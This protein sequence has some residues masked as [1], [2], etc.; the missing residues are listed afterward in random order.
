[1]ALLAGSTMIPSISSRSRSD[2]RIVEDYLVQ[3][4]AGRLWEPGEARA[5][6]PVETAETLAALMGGGDEAFKVID[7]AF[8]EGRGEDVTTYLQEIERKGERKGERKQARGTARWMIG[9]SFPDETIVGATGLAQK[10]IDRIRRSMG[11][12]GA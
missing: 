4:A 11:L 12:A 10:E 6:H 2:F 7:R 8:R 5:D 3:S 9:R 1:M